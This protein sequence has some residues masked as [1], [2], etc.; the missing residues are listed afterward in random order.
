MTT[1]SAAPTR[2]GT[3]DTAGARHIAAA[4]A[5]AKEQGRAALVPYVVAG[6]PDADAGLEIALA[7]A[8]AGADLLEVG[9]PYS[10][11][12][13]DGAT[14]QRAS[15]MAIAAGATLDGSLRL[16][17]RIG[18]ARPDLPVVPMGYA[19]Q[20]IGGGD[21]AAVAGRL[22]RAGAAGLIVADLTPDE[23]PGF[24][25]VARE[26]GLAVVYLVAP[27]TPP[28]RRA[29]IARRSGGFLYCVSLVGVT[30]ARSTLPRTVGRLVRD[31]RAVSPVPVG[32]GFGVS[33][34]AQVRAIA[35]AGAD[36]VIVASAL[37]DA[38][39]PDGRDV[40]ALTRLVAGL[41]GATALAG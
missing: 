41:R 33:T 22:A 7:V 14:L 23:G 1:A 9:L 5:R 16:I 31:V 36:G 37:V 3:N 2:T 28:E 32:V 10:D 21:G 30:G 15:Q 12:L 19:N 34:P 20:V 27:T 26:A 11:P 39:G 24:E 29:A 17:E 18:A 8:D 13:A 38:L 4:F 35:R 40:A 6:Y 25:A